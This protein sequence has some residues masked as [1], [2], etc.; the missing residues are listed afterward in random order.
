MERALAGPSDTLEPTGS[1][2]CPSSME[3]FLVWAAQYHHP[4]HG[5]MKLVGAV[6][7]FL[8]WAM[9]WCCPFVVAGQ[10]EGANPSRTAFDARPVRPAP[11]SSAA[12]AGGEPSLLP[13]RFPVN[14]G[15]LELQPADSHTA[16]STGREL[17]S[18]DPIQ[19]FECLRNRICEALH[20]VVDLHRLART[21][22]AGQTM[23]DVERER[24]E[25]LYRAIVEAQAIWFHA[26]PRL[27][28]PT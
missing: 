26:R 8:T 11:L 25:M 13:P 17:W 22:P 16:A 1:G 19:A 28:R 4:E 18:R 9:N 5:I 7:D 2:Y 10:G 24:H 12:P 15:R 6:E 27:P 23:A 14:T 3:H 21:A 20:Y